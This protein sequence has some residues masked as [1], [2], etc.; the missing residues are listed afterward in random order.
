V[1]VQEVTNGH[2]GLITDTWYSSV[3]QATVLRKLHITIITRWASWL[4]VV[5]ACRPL[6]NDIQVNR[7]KCADKHNLAT[8][9]HGT[10]PGTLLYEQ[11]LGLMA[12]IYNDAGVRQSSVT[13]VMLQE[14]WPP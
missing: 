5:I 2:A 14:S 9:V 11:K 7:Q 10:A 12:V 4:Y 1:C 3:C 6:L 13:S 8:Q